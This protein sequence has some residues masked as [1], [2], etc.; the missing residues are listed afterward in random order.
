M[1]SDQVAFMKAA[2]VFQHRQFSAIHADGEGGGDALNNDTRL[3]AIIVLGLA[4]L[5][6]TMVVSWSRLGTSD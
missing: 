6:H 3:V 4:G 5:E 2:A 1:H